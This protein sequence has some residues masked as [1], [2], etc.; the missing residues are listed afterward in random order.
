MSLLNFTELANVMPHNPMM[1]DNYIFF[2]RY[3]FFFV[4]KKDRKEKWNFIAMP[5]FVCFDL[6]LLL[7][8]LFIT[9]MFAATDLIFQQCFLFNK[10]F[11]LRSSNLSICF[12][13][14]LL[15]RNIIL[16]YFTS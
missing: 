5:L 16:Y 9:T 3:F 7:L 15:F 14:S 4:E 12:F 8:L 6:P 13:A 1:K 10:I 11:F 2:L